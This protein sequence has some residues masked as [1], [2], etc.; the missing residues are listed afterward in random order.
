MTGKSA[1]VAAVAAVVLAPGFEETEA[2][3]VIDVLRRANVVVVV[4]GVGAAGGD[5]VVGNHGIGVSADAALRDVVGRAFDAVILPGGMP[6]AARL[7]DDVEVKAFVVA[8]AARGAV[9][10]ALCAAPI[11]LAAFGVVDGKRVTCFPGFEGDLGGA[12]FVGGP[13]V[14]DGRVVTGRAIGSALEFGVAVVA[15]IAGDD[16]AVAVRQRLHL[17]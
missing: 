4:V 5:V 15:A 9:V 12:V 11:A 17:P 3:A 7:R 14:V 6:G 1:A 16:V 8:A 10:A 13:V 2:V